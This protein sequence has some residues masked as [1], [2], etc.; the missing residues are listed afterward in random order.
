NDVAERL[1]RQSLVF[2]CRAK[3]RRETVN[4]VRE[5][6]RVASQGS[7]EFDDIAQTIRAVS[8]VEAQSTRRVEPAFNETALRLRRLS[9][10]STECL[11]V[12]SG[13]ELT[14]NAELSGSPVEVCRGCPRRNHIAWIALVSVV[15]GN[16]ELP[17]RL[18]A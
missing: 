12:A 10:R 14:A 3:L 6:R 1:R 15:C 11:Q 2:E 13:E 18:L 7:R 5:V 16:A 9:E 4:A 17:L 8:T